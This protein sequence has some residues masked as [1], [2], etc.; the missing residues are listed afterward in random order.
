MSTGERV[1]TLEN[2]L[3]ELA[4]AG[5]RTE[6]SLDRLS[7]EMREFKEE[8]REFKDEMHAFKDEMSVFKDEMGA[9]KDE[10]GVFKDEMG[11]YKD[12]SS[13]QIREMNLQWGRLANKMGTFVEDVVLPNFPRILERYFDA[14]EIE[15]IY[16]RRKRRHP[17]DSSR[18]KE[19]DLVAVTPDVVFVNETKSSPSIE[20]F[21]DF[22]ESSESLFEYLP[23]LEGRRVV[24]I[25][26]ALFLPAEVVGYLSAHGCY[27]MMLGDEIM[28][29]VNF[30]EVSA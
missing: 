19:L 2:A 7:L 24:R 30:D 9:F 11:A 20:A 6:M 22:V 15:D 5:R 1:D 10:M 23:E 16:I 14:T 13:R 18:R 27:A 29:L 12:E 4:Y 28:D 3:K 17:H 25:A 26:S 8:M 21:R